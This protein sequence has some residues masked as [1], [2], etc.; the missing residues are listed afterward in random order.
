MQESLSLIQANEDTLVR[1]TLQISLGITFVITGFMIARDPLIWGKS[2]KPWAKKLVPLPLKTAMLITAVFDGIV[3]MWLLTGW[4][5]P[6]SSA[7]ALLHLIQVLVM[8]GINGPQYR[9]IG[10]L[11]GSIALF[12]IAVS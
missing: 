7:L 2:V 3:G 5:L 12:I 10:L 6:V 4:F 8:T 9:D 11:G 1:L